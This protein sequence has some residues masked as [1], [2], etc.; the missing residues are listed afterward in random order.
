MNGILGYT[1]I[2]KK[3][4]NL[5]NPQQNS[6]SIIYQCGEHLL[7]LIDDILDLSKIEAQK[8]ELYPTEFHLPNFLN[9]LADLFKMRAQQKE[10]FFTYE[11]ISPLPQGVIADE[12]RLRQ[13]LSNLLSN[14]VKFTDKGGVTFKVGYPSAV[15]SQ[16]SQENQQQTTNKIRFQIEDTGIGIEASKLV[17]IFLPF[18]Q[19]GD[20]AHAVEGTGLG[21]AISQKLAQMMGSTIQVRS[22]LG[23][24]SVFWCDLDL[25]PV[26]GW[27]ESN[28][29]SDR[30][31]IGFKGDKRKVLIVDDNCVNRSI[32]RE[33]LEPLGFNIL[34]A[35]DGQ[36]CLNKSVE[37]RPDLILMDLVMPGT[38]GLETLRQLRQ[39]PHLKDVVAIA[40][41]ANV[42]ETTKQESLAVGCQDFLPKPVQTQQLLEL[43]IRH[44]GLEGIYE[45]FLYST[46][47]KPNIDDLLL[48]PLP[49]SEIMALSELVK[50]G[51]IQGIL[52]QADKLEKLDNQLVPFATQIRQLAKSFKLKQLREIIQQ[53]LADNQ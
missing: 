35:V 9:S 4:T 2:L 32:L 33:L 42:V 5:T 16:C 40:L 12:K 47:V 30:R 49:S 51:D 53:S 31:I 7:T 46:E 38:N 10:I 39:L 13:I 45:E 22:T 20:R 27:N 17:E 15:S 37:F 41:S 44:L 29:S 28:P 8:M 19:V 21:L 26:S 48:V 52:Q 18:H 14:A 3:N 1:Q 23:A 34:E 36:D 43:L 6:L 24:G 50:M 11:I 25:P